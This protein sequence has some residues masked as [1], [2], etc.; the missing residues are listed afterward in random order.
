MVQTMYGSL[1][2]RAFRGELNLNQA[3]EPVLMV[4]EPAVGY[5]KL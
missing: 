2:Q 5:N 3:E 1:S 4:A